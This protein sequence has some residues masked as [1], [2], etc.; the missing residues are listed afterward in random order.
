MPRYIFIMVYNNPDYNKTIH[1]ITSRFC[2]QKHNSF[3]KDNYVMQTK[4][5]KPQGLYNQFHY[6]TE[7]EGPF[8]E[9]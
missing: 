9:H 8:P 5:Y 3:V 7:F 4:M 6:G 1:C 2:T